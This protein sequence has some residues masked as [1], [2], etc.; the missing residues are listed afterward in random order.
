MGES[1]KR[2]LRMNFLVVLTACVAAANASRNET[3]A[4]LSCKDGK[5]DLADGTEVTIETPNYPENYPNKAKCSWKIGVPADEEVHVWCE[6][7]D[8]AKGDT[9]RRKVK[10]EK[11]SKLSGTFAE[12][13]GETIPASKK[14]RT[15]AFQFRSNK[16]N[17]AG[18]FRC[19]VAI[20][21]PGSGEAGSVSGSGVATGTGPSEGTCQCGN[22]GG[23][24]NG[25]IVGGQASDAHE[26]PWQVG[27]TTRWGRTPY[28]GGTLISPSHVLTAAHCID[29]PYDV[30]NPNYVK[31][32]LGEHSIA[33]SE[34]TK[35]DVEEVIMH[36]QYNT[37]T[38]NNDFAILRLS[39]PVNY[40]TEV[41]PACLPADVTAT[42]VNAVATVTGWG[43]LEN[44]QHALIGVVSWGYGCAEPDSPGVYARVTAQMSWILENSSGT[45][46]STCEA[47]N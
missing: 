35:A 15:L 43:T 4:A 13:W 42:Y 29:T 33:D 28:C 32:L 18:G 6:T 41:A 30:D 25:R 46:S 22:K 31:V 2:I 27:L 17:T 19:Q 23:A 44:G 47:L 39:S 14:K 37:R 1:S 16:K 36:P 20:V 7:F 40:T 12:G 3:I 34:N 11:L 5:A 24:A 38:L 21:A 8:L 9:L 26:Y 10:E 45:L